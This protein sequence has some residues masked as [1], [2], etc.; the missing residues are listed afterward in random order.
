M[1]T[2]EALEKR[3]RHS[4]IN[5]IDSEQPEAF[6]FLAL[7]REQT[8]VSLASSKQLTHVPDGNGWFDLCVRE[9]NGNVILLHNALTLKRAQYGLEGHYSETIFPNILVFG[10]KSLSAD[11]QVSSI[12]FTFPALKYFLFY[13]SFE[14]INLRDAKKQDF[15]ALRKVKNKH[16]QR[17]DYNRPSELYIIHNL[18]PYPIKFRV[19][20]RGYSIFWGHSEG[21]GRHIVD[22]KAKPIA[23]I[24]FKRPVSID[25]AIDHVWDWKRFFEQ[26]SFQ[27]LNVDSVSVMSNTRQPS[28]SVDIYLPNLPADKSTVHPGDIPMNMWKDR[29]RLSVAMQTWLSRGSK[30]ETFRVAISRVLEESQTR[31]SLDDIVKLCAAVES[32]T[33]FDEESKISLEQISQLAGAAQTLAKQNCIEVDPQRVMY[34]RQSR[35]LER[36]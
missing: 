16:R 24:K 27:P 13:Q 20:D 36:I 5:L 25:R 34:H 26:L 11:F 35:W 23:N 22:V 18:P 33:E 1:T 19:E 10:D 3:Y 9:D 21:V 31:T 30:R 15:E 7:T 4:T 12:S 6:G 28:H 29:A 32:L 14:R 2:F 17:V 8:E